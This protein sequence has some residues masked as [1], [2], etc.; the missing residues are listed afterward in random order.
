MSSACG[1][2]TERG[3]H[4]YEDNMVTI[5][6]YRNFHKA[7]VLMY[8]KLIVEVVYDKSTKNYNI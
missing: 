5:L 6:Q 2:I 4:N 3:L 1:Y 7:I 8:N